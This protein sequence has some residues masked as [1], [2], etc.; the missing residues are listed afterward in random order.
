MKVDL[1]ADSI[2]E[3]IA[4]WR[5]AV[6]LKINMKAE[7]RSHMMV[8]RADILGRFVQTGATWSLMLRSCKAEGDDALELAKLLEDVVDFKAW[9]EAELLALRDLAK[10]GK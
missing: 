2:R 7:F 9:A 4:M 6:D 8:R 1:D 3:S 5:D 10:E